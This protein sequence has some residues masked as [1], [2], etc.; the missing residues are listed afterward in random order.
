MSA[1]PLIRILLDEA[2]AIDA[3]AERI[4]EQREAI[5]NANY[6]EMQDLMK[7]VQE[8]F[9]HVQAQEAQRE[10]LTQSL[11][12]SL[13]CKPSLSSISEALPESEAPIFRGAGDQL[14]HSLFALKSEMAI[15]KGLIEQNES[16]NAML[17]S[18]WRRIDV[19]FSRP[20]GMDFRG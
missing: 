20:G 1:Q 17:L 12:E 2:D 13:G 6:S 10:K 11:A 19:D 18:E 9:F 3:L 14:K 16:F 8:L 5:K 4:V 15:L 7:T